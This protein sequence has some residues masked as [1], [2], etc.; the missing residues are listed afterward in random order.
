MTNLDVDITALD[1]HARALNQASD[2]LAEVS[3][4]ALT[5]MALQP[6]AFGV[7]CSFLVPV[8]S[9]Q[10]SAALAGML[11]VAGAV[12]AESAAIQ[13]AALGYRAADSE[14]AR[15]LNDLVD[16]E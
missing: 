2:R 1:N 9:L 10:Q 14:L 5:T 6:A 11:A 8:M 15:M 16:G 4:A 7:L 12:E 3:R 13:V